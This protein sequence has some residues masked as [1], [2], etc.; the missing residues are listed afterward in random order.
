[1]RIFLALVW[2]LG[3]GLGMVLLVQSTSSKMQAYHVRP[4]FREEPAT[5]EWHLTREMGLTHF[6]NGNE[7]E[8][9]A[10]ARILLTGCPG[11]DQDLTYSFFLREAINVD[12]ELR[13]PKETE[14]PKQTTRL[15]NQKSLLVWESPQSLR[16]TKH[17]PEGIFILGIRLQF[18][19]MPSCVPGL[20][21]SR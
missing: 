12:A 19:E 21:I 10:R 20:E 11:S 16:P 7:Y 18:Q 17:Y 1:M 13:L 5:Q 2:F 8:P 3:L 4:P 15:Q 9:F 6:W 14:F